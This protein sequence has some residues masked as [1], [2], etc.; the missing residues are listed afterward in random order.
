MGDGAAAKRRHEAVHE[1][2]HAVVGTLLGLHVA[3]VGFSPEPNETPWP[4]TTTYEEAAG[5]TCDLIAA[6]P[7]T[8][9]VVLMAGVAAEYELLGGKLPYSEK[10]DFLLLK[11]CYPD[12]PSAEADQ[13]PL[14]DAAV[15]EATTFAKALRSEIETVADQLLAD[16]ELAGDAVSAIL[17]LPGTTPNPGA[18]GPDA[19]QELEK[20]SS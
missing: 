14:L 5:D 8:M 3:R 18:A 10:G 1:A 16:G 13:K 19:D 7:E 17:G 4:A 12:F 2:G 20:P 11:H 9:I 15:H 6:Q